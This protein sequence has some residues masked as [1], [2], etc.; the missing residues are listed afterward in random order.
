MNLIQYS[1]ENYNQEV[2]YAQVT[3]INLIPA[4]VKLIKCKIDNLA[5]DISI[6]N[7]VGLFKLSL[8]NHLESSCF[9]KSIFKRTL[10]LIK[11]WSYYE[12][13]ILGSNVGLMASYAIE[14]LTIYMFNNFSDKFN[15]EVE[16]LFCF[17]NL[18]NDIDWSKYIVTIFGLIN[19]DTYHEDLK[20]YQFNLNDVMKNITEKYSKLNLDQIV[21]FTKNFEKLS[22]LDKFQN[23]GK[24][25][26]DIRLM[27]II[28]P[29]FHTNNLGKSLNYHNFSK[30]KKVF[31]FAKEDSDLLNDSKKKFSI[32]PFEYF[33]ALAKIF[34]KIMVNNN[35]DLFYFN[36]PQPKIII[37]PLE[38]NFDSDYEEHEGEEDNTFIGEFSQNLQKLKI[39][40][41]KK[42]NSFVM[43]NKLNEGIIKKLNEKFQ[44]IAKENEELSQEKISHDKEAG[45]FINFLWP[46]K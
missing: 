34:S 37:F 41:V 23:L 11:C 28:D 13:T 4:E 14:V 21:L 38:S 32:S 31:E 30:I 45:S 25:S 9:D 22:N 3:E 26:I 29:I 33:N 2:G 36:I 43:P 12:G 6:N 15:N 44:L 8:M 40:E 39:E 10:F 20:N 19:I 24:K 35:P 17:F 18:M 27:N 46:T 42:E 16:A 5:F 7:F 1:L